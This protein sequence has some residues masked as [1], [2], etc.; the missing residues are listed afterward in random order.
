M[1]VFVIL[2]W[3][4]HYCSKTTYKKAIRDNTKPIYSFIAD[5]EMQNLQFMATKA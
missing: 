4:H 3:A 1:C 2:F 5:S